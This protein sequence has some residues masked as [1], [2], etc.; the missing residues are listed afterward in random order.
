MLFYGSVMVSVHYRMKYK[1]LLTSRSLFKQSTA[2]QGHLDLLWSHEVLQTV[3]Q[4]TLV[5]NQIFPGSTRD[6]INCG[7]P[8]PLSE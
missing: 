1:I 8:C 4:I 6:T 2:E 3:V 7:K 5:S